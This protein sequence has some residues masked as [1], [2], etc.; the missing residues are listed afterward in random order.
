[1]FESAADQ[2]RLSG[3]QRRKETES[4]DVSV[5]ARRDEM[6]RRVTECIIHNSTFNSTFN[7]TKGRIYFA[8]SPL[9]SL[10]LFVL[11]RFSLVCFCLFMSFSLAYG[12]N[13]V[14]QQPHKTRAGE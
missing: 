12:L 11:H 5:P 13:P 4:I 3:R 6:L 14:I 8:C 9:Q 7:L 1:M 10:F 2:R